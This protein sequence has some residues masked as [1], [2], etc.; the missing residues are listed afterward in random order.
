MD[1][2]PVLDLKRGRAVHARRGERAAYR[3]VAGAF[4]SGDDPLRLARA[5]RDGLGI[6]R[7]YVA[8]LD[9]ITGEEPALPTL[10][11]LS[12]L[13]LELWVDAGVRSAADAA[14]VLDEGAARAIVAL[15]TLPGLDALRQ[16]ARHIGTE[17]V[18]LSLDLR[19]GLPLAADPALAALD[20]ATIARE[21]RAAGIDTILAL[22]LA[23]VGSEAGPDEPLLRRLRPAVADAR[24]I[25][26]GGVRD[27]A[28]L[29]R[30]AALGCDGALV[31]TALHDGR[32]GRAE[33]ERL[34]AARAI[35][36]PRSVSPTGS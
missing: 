11:A 7:L 8:D 30:L 35:Q 23:R 34:Q 13:G 2:I 19:A 25:A 10:A 31:A 22:D 17:R 32:I 28:D 14:R 9:A 26:G 4:G 5:L 12:A 33:V 21:A 1:V 27:V 20:P 6:R 15:E 36:S 29:E 16:V 3:P 24:L 18:A